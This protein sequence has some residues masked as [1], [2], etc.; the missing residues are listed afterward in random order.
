[1][2]NKYYNK[3]KKHKYMDIDNYD[4]LIFDYIY[5]LNLKNATVLEIGS[6]FGRYTKALSLVSKKVVSVEPNNYMF[7]ILNKSFEKERNVELVKADIKYLATKQELINID[8]IFLVHVLHH[9]QPE[10]FKLIK[11]LVDKLR[12]KLIIIEPNHLNPLF[13]IQII[14]NKDMKFKEERRMFIDNSG[15][16]YKQYFLDKKIKRR[17]IGFLPRNITNLLS[18]INKFFS[19][20]SFFSISFKNPFSA[21]SVLEIYKDDYKTPFLT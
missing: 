17:F 20:S 12:A 18:K 13:L 5:S 3:E 1:M 4:R 21:Y 11:K 6:G 10:I 15:L 16:L 9:L 8:Y 2:F 14:I 19:N 7:D